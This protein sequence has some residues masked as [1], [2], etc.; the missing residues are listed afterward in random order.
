MPQ[1]HPVIQ[2]S[3]GSSQVS[4]VQSSKSNLWSCCGALRVKQCHAL[5]FELLNTHQRY[6]KRSRQHP[7][8]PLS[9]ANHF[10]VIQKHPA[11][12]WSFRWRQDRSSTCGLSVILWGVS[13]TIHC[14]HTYWPRIGDISRLWSHSHG[15]L[16]AVP[17]VI[18]LQ[19]HSAIENSFRL[20]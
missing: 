8:G 17:R 1:K 10:I 6:V 5:I 2:D 3:F 4:K 16:L 19:I 14:T 18:M 13:R 20:G 9:A 7:H 11:C 12:L 15:P